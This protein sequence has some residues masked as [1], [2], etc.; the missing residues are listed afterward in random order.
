MMTLR[1]DQYNI[2]SYGP[3]RFFIILLLYLLRNLASL[4]LGVDFFTALLCPLENHFA[5]ALGERE[6][7]RFCLYKLGFE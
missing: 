7:G 1:Q 3:R 2:M 4:E 5:I 6:T